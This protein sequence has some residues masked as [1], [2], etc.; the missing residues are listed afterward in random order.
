MASTNKMPQ[1]RLSVDVRRLLEL[2]EALTL[3]G[4]RLE[5]LYWEEQ[6]KQLLGKLYQGRKNKHVETALDQLIPNQMQ[7][8]EVLVE[9]AETFSESTEIHHEVDYDVLL[10]SAPILIWTRYQLP[11]PT[12]LQPKDFKLIET[13]FRDHI[14][15]PQHARLAL[16]PQVIGFE[17]MP[18]SFQDTARLTRQLG[19]QAV[20]GEVKPIEID[21]L[22]HTEGMLA[23]ARFILA[24]I[25]VPKGQPVFRW[26]TPSGSA[27]QSRKQS[28]QRWQQAIE[29]CFSRLFAGCT[30]HYQQPEAF[31]VSS[32]EADRSIRPL[33]LKAAAIWLQNAANLNGSDIRAT[34]VGCGESIVE[35]YRVGFTTRQSNQVIYGCVWPILSKEEANLNN[36]GLPDIP[37]YIAEQLTVAGIKEIKRLNGLAQGE[38]CDDC[39]APFFPN[40]LGEMMHPELPEEIDLEPRNFH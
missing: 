21:P 40:M 36:E 28:L 3:S 4:S 16:L 24:A 15:A 22:T 12:S 25:A 38:I 6:L 27:V 26:Q 10:V 37:D 31:F 34:I 1:S 23:D 19:K 17:Q 18:Q 33:A 13:A 39:G 20:T 5:D 30:A 7:A 9:L 11:P 14:A 2:T 35:E 32:R 8:Y 29:P